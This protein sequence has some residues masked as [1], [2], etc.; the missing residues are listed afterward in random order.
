MQPRTRFCGYCGARATGDVRLA[1]DDLALAVASDPPLRRKYRL[2]QSWYRQHV[3]NAD[4]GYTH[5]KDSRPVG[6]LLAQEEVANDRALNFLGDRSILGYVDQRVPAVQAAS[7]TLEER[8]LRHNML[9]SMPMAFNLVAALRR[10]PDRDRIVTELFGVDC[11]AVIDVYAE[12]TPE[13]PKAELLNDRTAFDA[14]VLYRRS[15]GRVGL[16]GIETKYTEPLSQQKYHSDRYVQVTQECGW[17]RGG[18]ESELVANATNQLW[19]NALLAAVSVGLIVDDAHLAIIGLD[20]DASLWSAADSVTSR[21]TEP[22]RLLLR[23]WNRVMEVLSDSSLE[24]FAAFFNERYLDTSPLARPQHPDRLRRSTSG[25]ENERRWAFFDVPKRP[26][27]T[28]GTAGE[29]DHW[30]SW[31]PT[32]WRALSD[33]ARTIAGPPAPPA[34]FDESLGWWTPVVHLMVYSLGWQSPAQGLDAWHRMGRPLDDPCLSLI[35][36]IWGRHLDAMAN[37]LWHGCGQYETE[38]ASVLNLPP[39]ERPSIPPELPFLTAASTA[40]ANP[41]TGGCD[42]LHLSLHYSSPLE[43]GSPRSASMHLGDPGIAGPGR[44]VLR[45]ATYQGWYRALHEEG[46]QLPGRPQGHGWRVDVTVDGI[47]YLGT[48]R[49]SRQTKRWFAGR[50]AVHQLGAV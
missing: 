3:L 36:V 46:A 20:E 23:P 26:L 39:V 37:Y 11:K 47:G 17:F 34:D 9:S 42:P 6:S 43:R 8:R 29:S 41:A 14:A 35:E 1:W 33:P 25:K 48:Y 32:M 30:A 13:R 22:D 44:A 12:W 50:H 21:M 45:C 31:L 38:V 15:D 4:Y 19:R 5:R 27:S 16:V 10:A 7:G 40:T 18:A 28:S 49:R 24:S 2:L